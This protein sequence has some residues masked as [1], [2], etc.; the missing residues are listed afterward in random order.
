[1]DADSAAGEMVQRRLESAPRRDPEDEL[2]ILRS[3]VAEAR[4][5]GRAKGAGATS[6]TSLK[7]SLKDVQAKVTAEDGRLEVRMQRDFSSVNKERLEKG[8]A[9]LL[10]Q[11]E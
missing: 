10:S 5:L 2:Q 7:I 1:M 11:I 3:C 9:A 8:I 6:K 4:A